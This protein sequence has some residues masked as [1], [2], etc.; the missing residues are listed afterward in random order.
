VL[1]FGYTP[2][3]TKALADKIIEALQVG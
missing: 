3:L 1:P 2:V